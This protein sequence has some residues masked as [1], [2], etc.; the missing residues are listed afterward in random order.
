MAVISAEDRV[1]GL[2]S[3]GM[4]EGPAI[5]GTGVSVAIWVSVA[6]GCAEAILAAVC[7]R[8][9]LTF[10]ATWVKAC[11]ALE[12][13]ELP[14]FSPQAL[15]IREN[16]TSVIKMVLRKLDIAL[17]QSFQFMLRTK[18]VNRFSNIANYII[19]LEIKVTKGSHGCETHM[20]TPI[21]LRIIEIMPI[22]SHYSNRI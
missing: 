17:P 5:G 19:F 13:F 18:V 1:G 12:G 2:P 11:S 10:C 21:F 9:V 4:A 8:P 7:V 3:V 15:S 22:I 6:T 14:P 20:S 16:N